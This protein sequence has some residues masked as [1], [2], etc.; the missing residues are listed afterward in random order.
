LGLLL[1]RLKK[2]PKK[3]GS[4]P[5]L[6]GWVRVNLE[7]VG[8]RS[9]IITFKKII[10]PGYP[11]VP[12]RGE[13]PRGV[14]SGG[15][16]RQRANHTEPASCLAPAQSCASTFDCHV[17][18]HY[19]SQRIS[20]RIFRTLARET[21]V[22]LSVEPVRALSVHNKTTTQKP[23]AILVGTDSRSTRPRDGRGRAAR[24]RWRDPGRRA[25]R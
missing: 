11:V 5:A 16:G 1:L 3:H 4:S 18:A 2:T 15:G 7:E 6:R 20:T 12:T 22:P 9:S 13:L 14:C 19:C 17:H 10:P 23:H 21:L 24:Q 25:R 8:F